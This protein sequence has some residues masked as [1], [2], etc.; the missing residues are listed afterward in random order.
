MERPHRNNIVFSA[1]RNPELVVAALAAFCLVWFSAPSV[2]LSPDSISYTSAA[3]SLYATGS[4]YEFDGEWLVDF[5]LGYPA[6]LTLIMFITRL[7]PFRF[8]LALNA[9]LFASLVFLCLRETKKNGFPLALRCAYGLCLLFSPALLQVYGMLWSET[10]FILCIALF[11]AGAGLYGRTHGTRALWIMAGATAIACVTRYI[12]II[13]VGMGV[14]LLLTDNALPRF[15]KTLHL[16]LFGSAGS[17]LLLV[18]LVWN[19]LNNANMAGDRLINQ[20]S[21]H[22]HL[23]RFGE[24]LLRWLP[25][26]VEWPGSPSPVLAILCAAVFVG[27]SV[28][29]STYLLGRKKYLYSWTSLGLVF[30]AIYS[31]FILALATLTAFQPLDSRLLSPLWFPALGAAAGG[32]FFLRRRLQGR[33]SPTA[34]KGFGFAVLLVLILPGMFR[35]YKYIRHPEQVYQDHI[36]Y[37]F[38]RYRQSPTLQFIDAH[39]RLFHSDKPIYS[40]AGEVLYVLCGLESEYPPRLDIPEEIRGFNDDT[41][42]LVWLNDLHAYQDD[43]LP[44]L[45]RSSSLAPLYSFPDG[46]IY[47]I[48]PAARK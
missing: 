15:K 11:F 17:S 30:T 32:I 9:I 47:S 24:T 21:F 4:P 46:L 20:V 37:D 23:Q 14:L 16:L 19:R 39:P 5:P 2:G 8:G 35:E 3:R 36:R 12:G 41:A 10:L 18:N 28:L 48:L 22:E 7:D 26:P 31:L 44:G 27:G 13:L 34:V 33:R 45:Q 42:Y 38:N 40:N 1:A 43:Y 29:A 25:F 6:W